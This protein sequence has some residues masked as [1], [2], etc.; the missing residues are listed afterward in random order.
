MASSVHIVCASSGGQRPLASVRR[1][2]RMPGSGSFDLNRVFPAVAEVIVPTTSAIASS[3]NGSPTTSIPMSSTS[4]GWPK[5]T[6]V[7]R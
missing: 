4:I 6:G 5:T 7:P 3:K 2:A 1:G